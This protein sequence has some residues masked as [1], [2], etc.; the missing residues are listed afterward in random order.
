MKEKIEINTLNDHSTSPENIEL[1]SFCPCC[2]I[3]VHPDVLYGS[4][5]AHDF[6]DENLIFLLNFAVTVKNVSFQNM[7]LILK[8]KKDIYFLP[9]PQSKVL[10]AKFSSKI[11]ELSPDFVSIYKDSYIAECSGLTSICGMGY[12]KAL[13]FL[14]KDYAIHKNSQANERDKIIQSPL[15]NCIKNYIQDERLVALAKASTWLGNDETH[16]IKKHPS[17]TLSN[18]K[19]FINAFLTFIDA[20]L[21]Y[22]DAQELL[23]S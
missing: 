6:E 4:C 2:G 15:M 20:D 3:A 22:E 8:Q 1:A 21:A 14:I 12:R 5:I 10:I 23:D 7:F 9:V 19:T 13:E 18:L 17:Y 11:E 16:Y